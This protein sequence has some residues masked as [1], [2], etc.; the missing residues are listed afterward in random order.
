[1]MKFTIISILG[2][3]TSKALADDKCWAEKLG[4]RCCKNCNIQYED[5]NGKWGYE[6][7]EWC[8]ITDAACNVFYKECF[9]S[10]KY[11]CCSKCKIEYS[12]EE[13]D[14]GWE[15]GDWCGIKETCKNNYNSYS[16]TKAAATPT[17]T[18]DDDDE[19]EATDDKK[20]E[21]KPKEKPACW[22]EELGYECCTHCTV[23]FTDENGDWGVTDDEWCGIVK[24]CTIDFDY[25]LDVERP[26]HAIPNPEKL[27]SRDYA[28]ILNLNLRF[29]E[30]QW[31]GK[32][33]ENKQ[34]YWRYDSALDDGKDVGLDLTGG[35]YD[36]GDHVKFNLPMSYA[37][38]MLAWGGIDLYDNYVAAGQLD[39]LL[40][41][42]NHGADYFV[43]C[44][45]EKEVI[46]A[47]VGLGAIDHCFWVPP[48][49]M[50]MDR[51]TA[52]KL[53]PENGCSDVTAQMAAALA[54]ASILNRMVGN[55]DKAELYLKHAIEIYDFADKYRDVYNNPCPEGASFYPS[56]SYKDELVWGAAWVYRASGDEKYYQKADEYFDSL[57]LSGRNL[58][59]PIT[60][61]DASSGIVFLMSKPGFG[62][63][64]ER[65]LGEAQHYVDQYLNDKSARTDGGMLWYSSVSGWGSAR[66]AMAG[67]FLYCIY[68]TYHKP[69]DP[70]YFNF[71]QE[72]AD[73][74]LGNNPFNRSLVV[75]SIP[76]HEPLNVHHR[77]SHGG[78]SPLS[79]PEHN[80]YKLY[81]ALAGGPLQNDFWDDD[82]NNYV[83]NEVACDYNAG[84]T[85]V[86]AYLTPWTVS[87]NFD[88]DESEPEADAHF[89]IQI[90]K[91]WEDVYRVIANVSS[92]LPTPSWEIEFQV[93]IG[94][95]FDDYS[96]INA[97]VVSWDEDTRI[98][99]LRNTPWNGP[100]TA[101]LS[102]T[103]SYQCHG[104]DEEKGPILPDRARL[105]YPK[106]KIYKN[107]KMTLL[108]VDG[109]VLETKERSEEEWE[110]VETKTVK[111]TT[112]AATTKKAE[113]E[114]QLAEAVPFEKTFDEKKEEINEKRK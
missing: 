87:D 18:V 86:M 79:P 55:E 14:W 63:N 5:E 62:S 53:T 107:M 50:T 85:G 16:P 46:Y 99:R 44:H 69:T 96:P 17:A 58:I 31:S 103:F 102:E 112:K 74:I 109:T 7:N 43:R 78:Y 97:E 88:I 3:L 41:M 24:N 6:K 71:I 12:D 84:I 39:Y 1:M 73:Y 114:E 30:C 61:D 111:K 68:N 32:A 25:A 56:A 20:T 28:R 13:G 40:Q 75:G 104:M 67:V 27:H 57:A 94:H 29:Y 70:K 90:E 48:E 33:P 35:F 22:A 64:W 2:L 82:R 110:E 101:D 91:T 113:E 11:P 21:E 98:V 10:P 45:P 108:D 80:M 19:A 9:S 4:Y 89:I 49:L 8:G 105:Y 51:P 60:W 66:H 76:G 59:G 37:M 83:T 47:Q 26:Y 38:T 100:L 52:C 34:V 54:S 15:K 72:Q 65:Y 42:V 106:N 92:N 23:A 81:G 77:G 36:A 93:P 95:A